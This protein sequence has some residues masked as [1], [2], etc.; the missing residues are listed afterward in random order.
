MVDVSNFAGFSESA[1]KFFQDLREN[2]D[3]IWFT[4]HKADYEQ[5]VMNPARDFVMAMGDRLRRRRWRH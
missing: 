2:N 3:K 4:D 1:V 5:Y